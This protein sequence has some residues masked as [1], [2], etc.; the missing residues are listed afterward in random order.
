MLTTLYNTVA[1]IWAR[2]SVILTSKFY[3]SL[4]EAAESGRYDVGEGE[5]GKE[6]GERNHFE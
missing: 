6:A 3:L 1:V 4:D 2:T 5:G